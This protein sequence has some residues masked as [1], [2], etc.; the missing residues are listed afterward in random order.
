MWVRML[1]DS[2]WCSFMNSLPSEYGPFHINYNTLK[3]KWNTDELSSKLVQKE[4]RLK[5][6]RVHSVNLVNQRVDKKLKPKAKKIK[7]KQHATTLKVANGEK[8]E[9]QNNKC[10]FFKKEGHFQKDCP[11][12]KAWFE[13]KVNKSSAFL[14][15]KRLGHISKER[16][17]RLV[18]NEILP[19]LDFTNFGLCV[20]CIKGKQTKHRKKGAIRSNDLFEIIHTNICGPFDTPSFT[21]EKYFITFI[22]DFSCYGYVYLLHEKSQSINA[23]EVF[24]NEVERQL[25]KKVNIVRSDRG[26]EYYRKNDESGQCLGPFAKFLESHSIC[27]QYT[28]PGTPQQNGVAERRNRTLMEMVRSMISK[29]S[30]PKSLW[31]YA[32]RTAVYLLNRVPSKSVPKT[33]FELWTGR[34]PSLKHLHVWGCPTKARVYNPQEKKLDSRTVRGYFIGYPEKSKGYRDEVEDCI[35]VEDSNGSE[36]IGNCVNNSGVRTEVRTLESQEELVC[37]EE[38][39]MNSNGKERIDTG[40]GNIDSDKGDDE[41]MGNNNGS[42]QGNNSS[43]GKTYAK[44]VTKGIQV[45]SNKLDYIPTELN[46]DGSEIIVFDEAMVDKGSVQWK[47]TV[48]GNFVGYKMSVHELRYHIRRMWSKWGIDDIDM[49]ADGPWMVSNKPLFVRKWDP[50]IGMEKVKHTKVPLWISLVNVPLE[51]WSK[52][53]ISALASSLVDVKKGFKENIEI[54]YRDRDNNKKGS[55]HVKVEYA[56]KPDICTHCHVFGH[57]YIVCAKRERTAEE[58]E[59]DAKQKEEAIRNKNEENKERKLNGNPMGFRR[60]GDKKQQK[61]RRGINVGIKAN[62]N[63]GYKG[64]A[65]KRKET[66]EG[67][68][69]KTKSKEQEKKG[70]NADEGEEI[71]K[72]N[73]FAALND[74]DEDNDVLDKMRGRMIVDGFI[75]KKLQPNI[76]EVQKWTKDMLTYFKEQ[77]KDGNQK[78]GREETEDIEDVLENNSGIAK[79]LNTEEIEGMWNIRSM[80]QKKKQKAV[81]NF[82]KEE[83][84]SVCGIVETHIKPA[85]LCKAAVIAFGGWDWVSNSTHSTSGCRIMIGWDR[86]RVDIMVHHMTNQVMLVTIDFIK[87]KQKVLCSFVYASNSGVERRSLWDDLRRYKNITNGGPWLLMGDFN[88]TLN[89]DEHSA[90][91]SKIS[92]DMIEFRECINDIEVE[93]SNYSGLFYTWI[94]SPSKPDTSI[95]KK[96]D[97][98]MFNAEFINKYGDAH[99]RFHPFLTSDHSPVV[100]HI[101]NSL[102]K[103][104]KSFKF[105]NFIADKAEFLEVVRNDWRCDC[106]GYN[107]YKLVKKMKRMKI[108]L[109]N[110][111]WKNG[112]L[113]QN[114]KNLKEELKKAQVDVEANP[115][116]KKVKEKLSGILQEYNEAIKDEEKILAQKAKVRWL[117]EGDKNSKYFHNAIKSRMHTNRIMGVYDSQ[118]SWFQGED[119]AKQFVKHFE[120]FLGNNNEVEEID[121]PD[122]L[123]SNKL[124]K[125][126]SEYMVRDVTDAEI[127]EAM[128]G[129]GND[130]APG[131]DGF[132]A[133]FF[134]R[135]WDIVGKDVCEAIKEPIACC[136]VIY[137]CIS[138]IITKRLQGCLDKLVN[139]NQSAFIPGRLIQDNLLITQELLKGYNRKN[140]PPRCGLKIDIAKAYDTVN[141]EF[142]EQ[143]LTHFGMHKKVIG[144]IMMCVTSA[145][146]S[147]SVNGERHGYFKSGRGLRQGD[148]MSPYLFTLVMEVLTLMVQR[149]VNHKSV[150]VLK[151][152]LME[153]SKVSG[154]IPNMNKS[155]IFFGSVKEIEKKK[156]LKIM[157]FTV[158]KLPMK[159]LGVPLI[160]K[161][162]GITECNQLVERVKQKVNDWKNKALSYAGRLQLIAFF[163]RGAA[164][165]AW[166]TI[167]T[168]KSQDGLGIKR[169][170]PWNEA[171]L[172][173]HLWNLIVKKDSLWVKWVNIVKLKDKNIWEVEIEENDCGTWKAILNLRSKIRSN[174]WKQIGD[175]KSTNVWF[176]KW[177]NEGPLCEKLTFR[178]RYEAR[179]AEYLT[180][181]DMIE[182]GEWIWPS[183]WKST[184]S[185]INNIRAHVLIDGKTY[186][187]VVDEIAKKGCSSSI[188][189]VLNRLAIANTVYFIWNERNKRI[190]SHEQRNWQSLLNGI[191]ESIKL[192][193]LGLKVKNSDAVKKVSKEW[194]ISECLM[195]TGIRTGVTCLMS[196]LWD[197]RRIG[198]LQIDIGDV[199]EGEHD[200][201]YSDAS[202]ITNSKDHTS[203]TGWVFFLGGAV[204]SWASKKQ[205]C[206]TDSTME[207]E[208]VALAAAGMEA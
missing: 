81:Y 18:K 27:A 192:Q 104:K 71:S 17:Q 161:S 199:F 87:L 160:T 203:T 176:D 109:N 60:F 154:L 93:D 112:N 103:K 175:G 3:D 138:K 191:V 97:R 56:W 194:E 198:E 79:E 88:V 62:G 65:W 147:I 141:W 66:V 195:V 153:F 158:G 177:C 206:I 164:K 139:I 77:W 128:F 76:S 178:N 208:F 182:N 145:A 70:K 204:I 187:A 6:Q 106:E 48:C 19:N 52:E 121:S 162:I 193:L 37:E 118:G 4:A 32:L 78:E 12:R 111:A 122:E 36:V 82:I 72:K 184:F 190:F 5:K 8:K 100:L 110:L 86:D 74:M 85:K 202:W 59:A 205:T 69:D 105:S 131:P 45:T 96:F 33:P 25:D 170:G 47:L 172:C 196:N 137:K 95:L 119:V 155:T 28:M 151:Q 149:R 114:V 135:S 124:T 40:N 102:D 136:N 113:F 157:P 180:V 133:M 68:Y 156:I 116:C 188:G 127:K 30:L 166:K 80:N 31:I 21:G 58:I 2:S 35:G 146:F 39:V 200:K 201:G 115:N 152:G 44:M 179:L 134:K 126:E 150:E 9:P 90:G 43:D 173:K 144:W 22:D 107:M 101:P 92:G 53:G 51:A 140:G 98:V 84:I 26:G 148:P 24:V 108:P 183:E 54:Q 14:W 189:S 89:M 63:G 143:I 207:S 7:K 99:A 23:L 64:E 142:L 10:N 55:K 1:I 49:K 167:C 129:I 42:N 34:K 130:K 75:N 163:R 169:L 16:L 159:Y 120:T 67:K 91:G 41:Q 38:V 73:K 46:E 11:K 186:C 61:D 165:V 20:E 29:S 174:A 125:D 94:K 132:T 168:P 171:L 13:K 50:I 15:H 197:A 117:S 181:Y 185:W 83:K 57:N 123:F